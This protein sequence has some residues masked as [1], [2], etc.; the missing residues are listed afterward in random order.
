MP[1]KRSKSTS[2]VLTLVCISS[3]CFPWTPSFFARLAVPLLLT[4]IGAMSVDGGPGV[5]EV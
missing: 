1:K 4:A 5:F 2:N 3:M